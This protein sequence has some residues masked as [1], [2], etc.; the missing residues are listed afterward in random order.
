MEKAG[1]QDLRNEQQLQQA[2]QL[3]ETLKQN[4]VIISTL[5][6]YNIPLHHI[7]T[8]PYMI[9]RWF[10]QYEP[11]I[12]C[13]GL[14]DCKQKQSGYFDNLIDD[15]YLHLEKRACKYK[16]SQLEQTRHL[17][18]FLINDM[19]KNMETTS[20]ESIDLTNESEN[21]LSAVQAC[22]EATQS[23]EGVYLYGTMGSGKTFLASCACNYYARLEKKVA[24]IHYP[25]FV[26]SVLNQLESGEY[27]DTIKK[28]MYAYFVVI[29]DIGAESVTEWNRDTILL[30][31]L[32]ARYEKGLLTWFTSNEDSETLLAHFSFTTKGK[33]EKTKAMRI[34]E[35]IKSQAK[36][37]LLTGKS[38]RKYL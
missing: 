1:F 22:L 16:V 14:Q 24:F 37:V 15:G 32:N 10:Q 31:I 25:T 6:H 12:G 4:P 30:P 21:Y 5:N 18:N 33:E 35:R 19:P 7:D 13:K 8:H 17:S 2:K 23:K 26:Q 20:F 38:R 36:P 28:L 3:S 29:D 9:Q 11:C 34:M 27:K